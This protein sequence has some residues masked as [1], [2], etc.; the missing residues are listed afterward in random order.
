[1]LFGWLRGRVPVPAAVVA[2]ATVFSLAHLDWMQWSL[3]L[4]AFGAGCLLAVLYHYS[5]SL[6]PGIAVHALNNTIAT[7]V[8]VMGHV[9]C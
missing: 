5:R 4:P 6:W 8:V 3:L 9:H 1:M 2:S 7:L